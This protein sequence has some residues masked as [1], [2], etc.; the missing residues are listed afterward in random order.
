M[1]KTTRYEHRTTIG[2]CKPESSLKKTMSSLITGKSDTTAPDIPYP[3]K[4]GGWRL[5]SVI[6]TATKE[7]MLQYFWEQKIVVHEP[8]DL[9]Q[10]TTDA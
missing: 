6:P 5:I 1:S 3:D 10:S 4:S 9:T 7:P 2:P 8:K